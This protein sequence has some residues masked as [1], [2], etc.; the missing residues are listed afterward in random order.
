MA[1]YLGELLGQE[2]LLQGA[3]DRRALAVEPGVLDR[4]G[5]ARGDLLGEAEVEVVEDAAGLRADEGERSQGALTEAHGDDQHGA[6][7]QRTEQL[8][9]A[10]VH[11][12]LL[13]HLI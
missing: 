10:L 11:G 1:R 8:E 7:A 2:A 13:E 5:G 4:D 6:K 12:G 9:V 3:G